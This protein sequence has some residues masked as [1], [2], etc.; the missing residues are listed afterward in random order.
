MNG[1]HDMGGMH[2]YGPVE[3]E[4]NEPVF[5]ARW[6]GV[7]RVLIT[8]SLN[9]VFNLDEMRH[10]IERIPPAEYIASSYYERWLSALETLMVEKR[11]LDATQLPTGVH[12]TPAASVEL[13]FA[14]S[15]E[16]PR[17]KP[18]DRVKTKNVHPTGHTRLPRY[19]RGKMG[20]V[21]TVNG[22]FILPDA[23]AHGLPERREPVYA[24]EFKASDLWGTGD[25]LVCV[26]CWQSYLEPAI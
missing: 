21:R 12:A 11:V 25:H 23:N 4:P 17:F 22:P 6:E 3:V 15:G 26:D 16:T 24:V 14:P 5:H 10:A 2:G 8:R 7:V 1:V 19:V 9:N 20:T 18:G 13:A